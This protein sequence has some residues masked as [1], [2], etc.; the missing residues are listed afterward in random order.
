MAWAFLR[1]VMKIDLV[2]LLS[3]IFVS[4]VGV[5]VGCRTK[6]RKVGS[7]PAVPDLHRR[8]HNDM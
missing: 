8:A 7:P 2:S 6:R 5:I 1:P 4:L 3:G